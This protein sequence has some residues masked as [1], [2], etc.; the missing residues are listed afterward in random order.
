MAST[1][2]TP[3]RIEARSYAVEETLRDGPAI[4][5]RAIRPDDKP[6]LLEHFAGLS[7]QT[8][9]FR[10]FGHK[11]ELTNQD[12][13]RF[14]EL[15][16]HRHVGIAATLHQNGRERFIGVGRYI[17]KEAPSRAEIALAVP[18]QYQGAGI[19]PLLI[20]HLARI[21]HDNGITEFEADVRGDNSRMLAVLRRSGCILSRANGAGIVHF[22]LNCPEH[23]ASATNNNVNDP[24]RRSD[25]AKGDDHGGFLR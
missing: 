22:T 7:A 20:R 3:R 2:A 5:I 12:L 21:A 15:D 16:F 13:A 14:T 25:G 1:G 4:E 19:G 24:G 23:S 17:R 10:F 11:R 8:R 9:Y 18:D 6:R